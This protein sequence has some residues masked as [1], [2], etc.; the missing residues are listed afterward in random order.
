[1]W[2]A[3]SW[4]NIYIDFDIISTNYTARL[5]ADLLTHSAETIVGVALVMYPVHSSSE[6]LVQPFVFWKGWLHEVKGPHHVSSN[7]LCFGIFH[8]LDHT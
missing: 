8:H 4:G 3:W 1:M 2:K 5:Q 7:V 6:V